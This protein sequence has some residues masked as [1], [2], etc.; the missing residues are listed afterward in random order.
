MGP[1]EVQRASVYLTIELCQL[2]GAVIGY[3]GSAGLVGSQA[4]LGAPHSLTTHAKQEVSADSA[5]VQN[6]EEDF[7][8]ILVSATVCTSQRLLME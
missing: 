7:S 3:G 5:P 4:T 6:K 2:W 1:Q 8:F